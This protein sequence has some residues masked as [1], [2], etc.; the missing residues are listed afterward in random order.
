[1]ILSNPFMVDP[2]VSK[3]ARS[4]VNNGHK[5]TVIVWDRKNDYSESEGVEGFK[6]P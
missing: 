2:R 5:V 6:N 1:M 3:E 4:L